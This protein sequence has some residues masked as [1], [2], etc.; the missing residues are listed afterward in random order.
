MSTCFGIGSSVYAY[1]RECILL[2]VVAVIIVSFSF[3]LSFLL[4][5]YIHYVA[6]LQWATVRGNGADI[7]ISS[8]LVFFRLYM[9][10]VLAIDGSRGHSILYVSTLLNSSAILRFYCARCSSNLQV[11]RASTLCMTKIRPQT[12][13]LCACRVATASCVSTS[14]AARICFSSVRCAPTAMRTQNV[15]ARSVCVNTHSAVRA[16]SRT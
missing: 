5:L 10:V 6:R 15:P 2:L 4:C 14:N 12:S 9:L 3:Y 16:A 11:Y 7:V 1:R 13:V 8:W